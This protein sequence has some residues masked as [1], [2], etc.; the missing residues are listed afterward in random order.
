MIGAGEMVAGQKRKTKAKTRSKSAKKARRADPSAEGG[1]GRATEPAG[2][3]DSSDSEEGVSSD[4]ATADRGAAGNKGKT[5]A[6]TRD[7]SA[8]KA[9]RPESMLLKEVRDLQVPLPSSCTTEVQQNGGLRASVITE[10]HLRKL[11]A[12]SELDTLRTLLITDELLNARLKAQSKRARQGKAMTTRHSAKI[13][14]RKTQIK[15]AVAAYQR[16]YQALVNLGGVDSEEFKPLQQKDARPFVVRTEDEVLGDSKKQPS[17]IWQKLQ[18]LDSA[19][20]TS[21]FEKYTKAS[22]SCQNWEENVRLTVALYS[23]KGT[24]VSD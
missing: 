3:R 7:K 12:R 23:D 24:L 19:E 13:N 9:H 4:E 5:K 1:V 2:G 16:A 10:T 15:E 18:F 11:Q 20:V 22:A 14:Q 8:K 17:W 6:R 21:N